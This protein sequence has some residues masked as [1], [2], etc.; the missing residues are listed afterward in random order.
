MSWVCE[1]YPFTAHLSWYTVHL[2]NHTY[3]LIPW[4][5]VL[6]EK[7]TSSQLVKKFP[8]FCG[9]RRFITITSAHAHYGRKQISRKFI[10]FILLRCYDVR[11]PLPGTYIF[12][13]ES[14]TQWCG[15]WSYQIPW[16]MNEWVTAH[17]YLNISAFS[18]LFS[19]CIYCHDK[20]VPVTTA[21]RVRLRMEEGPP[22]WRVAV[23]I[24]NK[25]SRTADKGWSYSLGVG[26]GSNNSPS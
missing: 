11:G 4:S 8:T 15:N 12:G 9:T 25:Q 19:L 24:L 10:P 20:W 3:L 18:N 7:L 22:I 16:W 2:Y 1:A 26:L 17:I 23:N 6:L 21:W 13:H 5:R 14:F